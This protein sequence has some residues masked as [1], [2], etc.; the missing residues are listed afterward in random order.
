MRRRRSEW[1]TGHKVELSW[2]ETPAI[3]LHPCPVRAPVSH[4]SAPMCW[5]EN[6]SAYQT[7]FQQYEKEMRPFVALNQALG[8]KSANLMRSKEEE[9]NDVAARAYNAN[10]TCSFY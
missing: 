9:C 3:A 2:W 1:I 5:P 7:A 6:W 10:Y 8:L 4:S